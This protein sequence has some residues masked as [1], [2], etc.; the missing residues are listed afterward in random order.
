MQGVPTKIGRY[1]IVEV[2]GQGATAVVYRGVDDE[3]A[4][5]V[6]VKVM[7]DH[8]AVHPEL[9]SGVLREGRALRRVNDR[10]VLAVHDV[11]TLADDR[12]FL[13]VEHIDGGSLEERLSRHAPAVADD[14]VELA[15]QLAAGLAALHEAGIVHADVKPENILLDTRGDR[16]VLDDDRLVPASVR[17]VLADGGIA[18]EAGSVAAGGTAG[19]QSP[20]QSAGRP[21]DATTDLHAATVIVARALTGAPPQLAVGRLEGATGEW[22]RQAT[23]VEVGERPA[24]ATEWF[25]GLRAALEHDGGREGGRAGGSGATELIPGRRGRRRP[26]VGLAAVVVVLVVGAVIALATRGD[27]PASIATVE[28]RPDQHQVVRVVRIDGVDGSN[29]SGATV[30]AGDGSEGDSGDGGAALDAALVRPVAAVVAPDGAVLIAD[31]GAH[32]VRRVGTD[33]TITTV[34]GTGRSGDGGEGAAARSSALSAPAGLA[35]AADGVIYVSDSG[36]H[37]VR[38]IRDGVITTIAGTGTPGRSGSGGAAIGAQLDDPGAIRMEDPTAPSDRA[39]LVIT[40]RAGS[41]R[42]TPDGILTR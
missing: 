35:V 9:R 22:A 30:I 36:N 28:A 24:T 31:A 6:A 16:S 23:S 21:V 5:D 10:H 13:V 26:S 17:L 15:S 34:A 42:L 38:E 4:V 14:V 2:I 25:G 39:V 12:P 11:G 7:S 32:R 40:D 18:T 3:L 8:L 1:R 41:A 27:G 33:G 29:G 19:Y 20:E 37:R